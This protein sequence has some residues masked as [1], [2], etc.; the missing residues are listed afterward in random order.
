MFYICISGYTNI[1]K[2]QPRSPATSDLRY[3]EARMKDKTAGFIGGGRVAR[4]LL[5]G[6][7]KSGQMPESI[8][9]S[10]TNQD[11]L[12]KLK[13]DFPQIRITPDNNREAA[14]KD[15]VF[16]GLHPPVLA[17]VL[18]EVKDCLKPE[19]FLVSLA[20]K[21]TIAKLSEM[22]GGFDRIL[23]MIPNAASIIGQGYNP[24]AFSAA[25]SSSDKDALKT[26]FGVLGKCPEVVEEMLEAYAIITAMGPTYLWFQLDALSKLAVSYGMSQTEAE[27]GILE[28]GAG[29][30]NTL[31]GSNMTAAEVMDL[32]PVKPLG[33]EENTIREI[34]RSK[35][36]PLYRKL[37][38]G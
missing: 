23:R 13:S 16:L 21:A 11:V 8:V 9:V 1:V 26:Y 25:L 30:L 33:E 38:N 34:Y 17:G 5:G 10:D 32:I 28:M 31:F 7:R 35:L 22:L 14:K 12:Q 6:F 29:A 27:S 37:K 24:V 4:I 20:P 19:T 2:N 3:W 15:L 36:E 18:D